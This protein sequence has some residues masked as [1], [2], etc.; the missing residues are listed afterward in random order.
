MNIELDGKNGNMFA[1]SSNGSIDQVLIYQVNIHDVGTGIMMTQDILSTW[2]RNGAANIHMWDQ[3]AVVDSRI[4][5]IVNAINANG[6][7]NGSGRY[8]IFLSGT[9]YT[10]MGSTIDNV[11]G[12]EHTM[13]NPYLDRAVI[14]SNYMARNNYS[15]HTWTLR[16]A[17]QDDSLTGTLKKVVGAGMSTQRVLTADNTFFN[18]KSAWTVHIAPTDTEQNERLR[19]IIFERNYIKAG[20]STVASDGPLVQFGLITL[21]SVTNLTVR[22][23]IVNLNH[24]MSFAGGFSANGFSGVGVEDRNFVAPFTPIP[25][26]RARPPMST[27]FRAYHNTVFRNDVASSTT[28]A[29]DFGN[30]PAIANADNYTIKNNLVYAPLATQSVFASNLASI[31]NLV[32]TNNNSNAQTKIDPLFVSIPADSVDQLSTTDLKIAP[33]S[34]AAGLGGAVPVFEDFFVTLR[35]TGVTDLGAVLK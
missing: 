22:N 21:G 31:P 19:D 23:N 14:G 35:T 15:K 25:D 2:L 33:G 26:P 20:L 11:H 16:G 5:K 1:F 4:N 3:F 12:G 30:D 32:M 24:A 29:F 7:E 10:L 28:R 18:D 8:G 27:G 9:R 6:I 34:Y 17:D 13:R